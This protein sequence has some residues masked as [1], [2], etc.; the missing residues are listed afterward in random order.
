MDYIAHGKNPIHHGIT[1][2]VA[3]PVACQLYEE[4]QDI[5]PEGVMEWII[6]SEEVKKQLG[7]VGGPVT[8]KEAGIS[9]DLFH[10][11]LI[12]AYKIRDRYSILRFVNEKNLS[13]KLSDKI[14]EEI[15]G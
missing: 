9:K 4:V 13:Q 2:G 14:T 12:E 10:K 11:S 6:P 7:K 3:T 8:P 5:L 15:Y 1:V